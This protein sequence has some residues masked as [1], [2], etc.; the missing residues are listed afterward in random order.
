VLLI[1]GIIAIITQGVILRFLT[2]KFSNSTLMVVGF[3]IIVI[4]LIAFSQVASLLWMILMSAF[5]ALGS[6]MGNP[7]N[8]ALLS[9]KS[10]ADKQGRISGINQGLAALMRVFA[11]LIGTALLDVQLGLPFFFGGGLMALAIIFFVVF[12]K[13]RKT[14]TIDAKSI[15]VITSFVT[16]K[17]D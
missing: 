8:Q 12:V 13:N 9:Q 7:T 11:P 6:S 1:V 2:K 17:L 5:I 16:E 14:K 10:P 15:E 4:G 3:T